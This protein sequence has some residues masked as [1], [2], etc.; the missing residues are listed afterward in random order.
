MTVPCK[1]LVVVVIIII[2]HIYP[3]HL[4]DDGIPPHSNVLI[5]VHAV[6]PH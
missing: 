5:I 6:H 3:G 2:V 4:G 1:V